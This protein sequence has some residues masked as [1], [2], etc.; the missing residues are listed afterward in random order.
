MLVFVSYFGL[1]TLLVPLAVAVRRHKRFILIW[2]G[3]SG[4]SREG[5]FENFD[6]PIKVWVV[7]CCDQFLLFPVD[8]DWILLIFSLIVVV[9]HLFDQSGV[10]SSFF[11][12]LAGTDAQ[13][14]LRK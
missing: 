14:F 2:A 1:L 13:F 12:R 8:L 5:I 10:L 11:Q 7:L 4:L 6:S 3:I 9:E